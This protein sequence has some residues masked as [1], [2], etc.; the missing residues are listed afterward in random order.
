MTGVVRGVDKMQQIDTL[1]Q[2][3]QLGKMCLQRMWQC[4]GNDGNQRI[5][6]KDVFKDSI[7][8][9][10]C[11]QQFY[12]EDVSTFLEHK[13]TQCVD[14]PSAI[15][16]ANEYRKMQAPERFPLCLPQTETEYAEDLSLK[17]KQMFVCCRI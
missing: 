11:K 14:V 13:L 16:A 8:C 12:L 2:R 1:L 15:Q 17:F 4:S 5:C 10:N 9:G 6:Q 3:W 7:S